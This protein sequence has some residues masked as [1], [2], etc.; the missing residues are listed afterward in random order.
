M[1]RGATPVPGKE[2][3]NHS[4]QLLRGGA[5]SSR[6]L[7]TAASILQESFEPIRDLSTGQDLVPMMVHSAAVQEHDFQVRRGEG[8]WRPFCVVFLALG[9]GLA[10]RLVQRREAAMWLADGCLE[11]MMHHWNCFV[12]FIFSWFPV[13]NGFAMR[14]AGG[15]CGSLLRMW[16]TLLVTRSSRVP[17]WTS[18]SMWF[19]CCVAVGAQGMHTVML[20]HRGKPVSVATLRVF[21]SQLAEMPLVATRE[22]AR[23][24]GHC[25]A[26]LQAIE[27]FLSNLQ[28][29][30]LGSQLI[31]PK[32]SAATLAC[33]IFSLMVGGF[34][35]FNVC[36]AN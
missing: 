23:R 13:V 15:R 30:V 1:A 9:R 25:R 35:F 7:Q 34:L 18:K 10:G 32:G 20:F 31:P 28:V 16:H 36:A 17:R 24:Q 14:M 8:G 21:G 6:L 2:Y 26:L 29:S 5:S 11:I 19:L 4:W 27:T 33:F 22:C 12:L 3:P